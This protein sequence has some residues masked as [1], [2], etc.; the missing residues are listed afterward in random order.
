MEKKKK[1]TTKKKSP[2]KK[3]SIKK[4]QPV[5][6]AVVP[7]FDAIMRQSFEEGEVLP[8]CFVE[9]NLKDVQEEEIQPSFTLTMVKGQPEITFKHWAKFTPAQLERL[10]FQVRRAWKFERAAALREMRI[11]EAKNRPSKQ[12][13][14]KKRKEKQK[15]IN[16]RRRKTD[17]QR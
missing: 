4:K 6:K 15:P 5:V 7:D 10:S 2:A 16:M 17:A 8:E 12:E 3:K 13:I 1:T 9:L 11:E 14:M